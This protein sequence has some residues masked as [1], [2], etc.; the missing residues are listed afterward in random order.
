MFGG[1]NLNMNSYGMQYSEIKK[2]LEDYALA[3]S[4]MNAS[5]E[6]VQLNSRIIKNIG[7]TM[8]QT[9]LDIARIKEINAKRAKRSANNPL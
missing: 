7:D 8:T 5:I 3:P 4:M 6:Y 9:C 2:L 1:N